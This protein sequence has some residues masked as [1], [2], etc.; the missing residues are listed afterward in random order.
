MNRYHRHQFDVAWDR[1]RVEIRVGDRV[2]SDRGEVG[3]VV[4]IYNRTATRDPNHLVRVQMSE[5]ENNWIESSAGL[6]R[7][8]IP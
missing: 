7:K 4:Q 3:T 8:V 1:D 6:W 2:E 5:R